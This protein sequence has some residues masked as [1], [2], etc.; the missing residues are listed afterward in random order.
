MYRGTIEQLLKSTAGDELQGK[1]KLI[2]TSPPFP[3]NRKKKYGNLTGDEYLEWWRPSWSSC[4]P[5]TGRSCLR[6]NNHMDDDPGTLYDLA[7]S[8]AGE[9]RDYVE[10]TKAECE[11]LGLHV[12]YD[13]DKNNEWWG[14]N[15]IVEQRRV[16]GSQT[17]FFVPFISTEYFAKPIPADE[18]QSAMMTAVKQGDDYVLPVL[19]GE[20]QVPSEL[21]RPHIHYLRV[22]DYAPAEL[23][24]EMQRRVGAGRITGQPARDIGE[25]VQ[26]AGRV[27]LPKVAPTSFSKYR[28]LQVAF[29]YFVTQ[30]EAAVGQLTELGFVG[31]VERLER[32]LVIRIERA[33]DTVYALD[34]DKGGSFG[35]DKLEFGIG[36]HRLG[37]NGINGY[38]R[39]FFDKD[40]GHPMLEMTDFSVLGSLGAGTQQL[41][42]EEL[43]DKLWNRIV[44]QLEGRA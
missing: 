40:A 11:R 7:F 15:F 37:G 4:S 18:F 43:F 24:R 39:P 30:F 26:E 29:D 28:E 10:Q 13:R 17:R 21:L 1:V 25:V 6:Y 3:L 31:T 41:T 19:I 27:R 34:I 16:Y 5:L 9:H 42:K 12:F 22:E 20:V 35:D 2:F 32:R 44:D 33:G 23:A 14:K 38:A 36:R 8:F